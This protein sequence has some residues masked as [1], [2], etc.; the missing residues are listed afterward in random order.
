METLYVLK[1]EDD[2]YYIGKSNDV[3]KRFE[4][5]KTG[6]GSSWT[7]EYK[8]VKILET[9][10]VTSIHDENNVTKDFMKKYGID[11]VRGGSY[12]QIDLPEETE[13]VLRME[14]KGNTDKCY[15]CGKKGHFA[16]KCPDK[17]S[18]SDEEIVWGCNYCDREFSS[19][20]G[21]TVHER[22]CG[23]SK[24]SGCCYRCGRKGHYSTECYASTHVKGYELDWS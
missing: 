17:E 12:C 24:Q 1:L 19:E 22:S 20:Y 18:E 15:N 9:R 5:H 21:A 8:P 10:P 23:K 14:I 11:N 7:R 6:K 13:S 2:K 4:Q 3:Q 16:N